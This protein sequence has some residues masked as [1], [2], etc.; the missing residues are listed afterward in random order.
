MSS[1][2]V[3]VIHA[4]AAGNPISRLLSQLEIPK[5][6]VRLVCPLSDINGRPVPVE[7]TRVIEEAFRKLTEAAILVAKD[8]EISPP[9]D[10]RTFSVQD[11]YEELIKLVSLSTPDYK[12]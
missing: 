9:T 3:H 4:L 11:V 7:Y 12:S 10:G 5:Q 1:I 8:I 6:L 2:S